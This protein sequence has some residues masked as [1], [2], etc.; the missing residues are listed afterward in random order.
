MSFQVVDIHDV[1][2]KDVSISKNKEQKQVVV[3]S[4]KNVF[5]NLLL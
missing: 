5:D 3:F 2:K 4:G 1:V